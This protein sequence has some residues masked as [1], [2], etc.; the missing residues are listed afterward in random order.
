M[1]SAG[2]DAGGVKVADID[3]AKFDIA[4]KTN[5]YGPVMCAQQ[6]IRQHTGMNGRI[7]NIT[8]VHEEIP[9]AGGTDDDC[10]KGALRNLT[11]TLSLELVEGGITVNNLAPTWCS[12]R[13]TR[14]RHRRPES[15]QGAEG[16]HSDETRAEPSEIAR[17]AVFLASDDATYVTGSNY[18][19]DAGSLQNQGQGA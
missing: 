17:L 2:V 9:R 12:H 18:V 6:F 3:L 7:I 15:A 16:G 10:S 8:S 13:S 5:L 14:R 1:N 11:R 4:L 19:M